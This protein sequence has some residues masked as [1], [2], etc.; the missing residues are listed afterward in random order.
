MNRTYLFQA[1]VCLGVFTLTAQSEIA[2][3]K[4][5][6]PTQ[7]SYADPFELKE[8]LETKHAAV[9]LISSEELSSKNLLRPEKFEVVI[10]PYGACFPFEARDAFIQYLK[11]GGSFVSM[12]GYAFD[13]LMKKENG[14]W[15]KF[16][17]DDLNLLLSGRRGQPGDWVRFQPDQIVIFDPTYPFKRVAK[18]SPDPQS[19]LSREDWSYDMPLEGFAV[20]ALS[21]G[22]S[23]VF[24]DAYADWH[25]LVTSYDRFG[26]PR[27]S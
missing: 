10:L 27:G 9:R 1:L 2:I 24:P 19:P 11:R 15:V 23:P 5:D 16:E 14:K 6:F 26:R 7:E 3:L 12:G 20:T 17:T 4:E 25:P 13:D 8:F 18:I 21:G 22:V